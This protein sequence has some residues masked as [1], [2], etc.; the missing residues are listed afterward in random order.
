MA[1]PQ[2]Q[3]YREAI[4]A[5][6]LCFS[7]PE[8][9][10][11]QPVTD[12]LGLPRPCAGNFA[13]VY[14][15]RCP[16]SGINWAVKC[17]TRAVPGLRD[18]Y[19]EISAHLQ[20]VKL[21]FTVDFQYIEEGIRIQSRWY[22]IL[23][24][25]WVEGLTLN[26][27]IRKTLDKPQTLE[28]LGQ[29]WL[30]MAQKLRDARLAHAD[31]QH[32]NVLLVA[33]NKP[34][35]VSL[36]LIDYDG[37]FVPALAKKKSG[38]VGHP[39]YQHPQRLK[40]GTYNAEVDRFSH[41]VIYTAAR[42]L[43]VAGR[44][45]W[46]RFD[47]GDNLLFREDDF[48]APGSSPV[49][50]ELWKRGH[51]ET[52]A[53]IGNLVLASQ[54]PLDRVP[55]L[56][57]LLS[58]GQVSRLTVAQEHQ[59]QS[60]LTASANKVRNVP[61]IQSS[62]VPTP[63]AK[64][65]S[66]PNPP[67]PLPPLWG[68]TPTV[69]TPAPQTSFPAWAPSTKLPPPVPTLPLSAGPVT[70]TSGECPKCNASLSGGT[71]KCAKCQGRL[72][73]CPICG[74]P[75]PD[76]AL[77]CGMCGK[78]YWTFIA[79]FLLVG[80][81]S[82]IPVLFNSDS[83]HPLLAVAV[84]A[85]SVGCLCAVPFSLTKAAVVRWRYA[86]PASGSPSSV[87]ALRQEW[88]KTWGA[89]GLMAVAI[90]AIIFAIALWVPRDRTLKGHT[91]EVTSLAFSPDGKRLASGSGNFDK[92]GEVKVWDTTTGQELLSLNG[93]TGN[94]KSVA[95]SIDGKQIIQI[96]SMS[97]GQTVKVWDAEKGQELFTLKGGVGGVF[98]VWVS[99]DGKRFASTSEDHG[100]VKVWDAQ[101]GQET[102]SI[103]GHTSPIN[104]VAFS[105]DGKRIASA[106]G[107]DQ[108]F[109]FVKGEVKVWQANTG[110]EVLTLKGHKS[111]VTSLAFSPD[112]KRLAGACDD[113]SVLVWDADKGMETLSLKEGHRGRYGSLAFSIDGKQIIMSK[114]NTVKVWDAE[115][116]QSV[117]T[118]KV[119]VFEFMVKN[120]LHQ[121][122][123]YKVEYGQ[124]TSTFDDDKIVKWVWVSPDGKRIASASKYSEGKTLK[125]E[126]KVWDV[127][128]GKDTL[129]LKGHRAVVTNVCFS[130]D[131]KRL[132]VTS[133][134]E[135]KSEVK[136][137]N[138]NTGQEI[139]SWQRNEAFKTM[140]FSPDSIRLAVVGE[141]GD[142][143]LMDLVGE[144][145][146]VTL[147]DLERSR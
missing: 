98:K 107:L 133:E 32:G 109:Q 4:Q 78:V 22:P 47:N 114:D 101:S 102:L 120:K 91:S 99:P 135:G 141:R 41:L 143:T 13:D 12:R 130:S 1:W 76:E 80:I 122:V 139:R 68:S 92:P 123:T 57:D 83:V 49:I 89:V 61:K 106:A 113:G 51:P 56:Q 6:A 147:M 18:R 87:R 37:M 145:G 5:P 33:G 74:T 27:F 124:E 46:D 119:E 24:M 50:R 96:I 45:L 53:L 28:A 137:W 85:V 100:T 132:G 11:G 31:L 8:L 34:G 125:G 140:V 7:D 111:D 58:K 71:R 108:T 118:F 70:A 128:K 136:I 86:F 79:V 84:L 94:V 104:C 63:V 77:S 88:L 144:R 82:P 42:C 44:D 35:A 66:A 129:S 59:V 2:S 73:W 15:V 67:G 48:K 52:Q 14:E 131:G 20:H 10:Q 75:A 142:V 25:A 112:G 36:K 30:R 117:F 127:D 105:I 146:D 64:S 90:G 97:N 69:H 3:E 115:N 116:G 16:A 19:R 17:F 39:A 55:W 72:K 21:P 65:P 134:G 103:K 9:R 121:R 29:L 54:G 40:D 26:E 60:L 126:V 138:A 62:P 110:T 81:G 38:E 95:F 23:K 93:R 43:A